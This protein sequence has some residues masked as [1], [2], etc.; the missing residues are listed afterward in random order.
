MFASHEAEKAGLA[1]QVRVRHRFGKRAQDADRRVG[2]IIEPER[3]HPRARQ[4]LAKLG[5]SALELY[6][7]AEPQLRPIRA[8][9]E[10]MTSIRLVPPRS[11]VPATRQSPSLNPGPPRA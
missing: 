3:D 6:G 10:V 1:A 4:L 8:F 11:K 2:Q 7:R 5:H 9:C